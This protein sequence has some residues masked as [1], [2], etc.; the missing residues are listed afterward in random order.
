MAD[1][2]VGLAGCGYWGINLARNFF[3]LGVLH[4]V[5]DP[6]DAVLETIRQKHPGTAVTADFEAVVCNNEIKAVAIAAPAA[7]HYRLAKRCLEAGKDVYVEKPLALRVAEAQELVMMAEQK[8]RILMVGHILQYHPAVLKLKELIEKK[9]LGDIQYI[10]SNRL[11]IGKLRTEENI[12]WSFAPHDISVI[13]ML[14]GKDPVKVSCTGA[15]CLGRDVYDSTITV[16]DFPG[17]IKG[18]IFVNW[19]HPFKEQKLI[20]VGSKSMAVFDDVSEEKLC[21]FP[22]VIDWQNNG[23]LPVARKAQRLVVPIEQKEPLREELAH[24]LSCIAARTTPRT[25]GHEGM[26]VLR[27]LEAAEKGLTNDTNG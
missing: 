15:R 4:T 7:E 27:V 22:H 2:T 16:L 1:K 6:V 10:Y 8:G 12:L 5:C 14:I 25:D 9:E 3:D 20:V 26:R 17:N 18:H 11:N 13:L 21:L 23:T 19:L 24:F